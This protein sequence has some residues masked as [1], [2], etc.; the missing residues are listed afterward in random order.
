M[1]GLVLQFIDTIT[2]SPAAWGTIVGAKDSA[3]TNTNSESIFKAILVSLFYGLKDYRF[4]SGSSGAEL[5]PQ[6]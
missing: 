5:I 6:I 3:K 1:G 2:V 4:M